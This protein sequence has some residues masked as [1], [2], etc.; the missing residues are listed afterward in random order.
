MS[1][2]NFKTATFE[3]KIEMFYGKMSEKQWKGSIEQ[4]IHMCREYCGKCPSYD[5]TGE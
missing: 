4:L 1:E 2:E 5:G 3:E